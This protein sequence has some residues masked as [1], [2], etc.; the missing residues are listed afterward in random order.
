MD[1]IKEMQKKDKPKYLKKSVRLY[2]VYGGLVLFAIIVSVFVKP[3]VLKKYIELTDLFDLLVGLPILSLFVLAP[4][5]LYYSW[6][7]FREKEGYSMLRFKY[8][9]G[10]LFFCLLV[11]LFLSAIIVD[12]SIFF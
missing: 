12:I 7:S 10:H 3:L 9:L 2:R 4:F 1:E 8:A 6:K 11:L 5:G